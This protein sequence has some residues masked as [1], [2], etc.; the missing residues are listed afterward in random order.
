MNR[1]NV[2]LILIFLIYSCSSSRNVDL[3]D[4]QCN[5]NLAFKKIFFEKIQNVDS[6]MIGQS[7]LKNMNDID[8]FFITE[9]N[10]IFKSSLLFI[11]KYSTVSYESMANY[12]RSY[13]Y[14]IYQNDRISWLKWYDENKCN[15][16]QSKD[17]TL[18]R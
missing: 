4:T 2:L 5:E 14:G 17:S 10:E 11:S 13:P 12:D 9:R 6:F 7:K 3:K 18:N 8:N 16:I 1:I 15:N